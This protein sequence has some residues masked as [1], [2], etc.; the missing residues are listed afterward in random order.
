MPEFSYRYK[1]NA[2]GKYYVDDQCL[3]CDLCREMIPD[4]FKRNEAG[5]YAYVA[6]QP[7][8]DE[9]RAICEEA[10]EGCP[11]EAVGN[12]G[13]NN[14]WETPIETERSNPDTPRICKHC[15]SSQSMWGRIRNLFQR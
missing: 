8:T 10:V 5:G 2:P 6:R 11:C 9:E 15:E 3:D 12:D 7:Q 13:N 4:V 1:D 14:D